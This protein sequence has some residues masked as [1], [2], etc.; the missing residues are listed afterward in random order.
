MEGFS[1]GLPLVCT[2]VGGCKD[3]LQDERD[4]LLVPPRDALAIADAVQRIIEDSPLRKRLIQEGYQRA[5]EA[6]FEVA[7]HKFLKQLNQVV[8]NFQPG[9]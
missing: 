3:T 1:Q 6:S 8:D 2:A 9:V 4:A 5:E 7:G